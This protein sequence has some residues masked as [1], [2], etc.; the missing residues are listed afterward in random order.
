[1]PE[2]LPQAKLHNRSYKSSPCN[3]T[4]PPIAIGAKLSV[5]TTIMQNS[6]KSALTKGAVCLAPSTLCRAVFY[7]LPRTKKLQGI[8]VLLG[9]FQPQTPGCSF[10]LTD[11]PTSLHTIHLSINKN[12]AVF[13]SLRKQ[14]SNRRAEGCGS[15]CEINPLKGL[16]RIGNY[17]T[18]QCL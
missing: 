15:L 1:M 16:L 9:L 7:P 11:K 3:P 18:F 8:F 10:L 6:R 5:I 14:C 17:Y 4:A 2:K 12:R 13:V